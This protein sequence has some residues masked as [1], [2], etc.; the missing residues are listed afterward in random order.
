MR[1]RLWCSG[2]RTTQLRKIVL[3]PGRVSVSLNLLIQRPPAT[4]I[5]IAIKLLFL[6]LTRIPLKVKYKAPR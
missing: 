4:T 3:F 6:M 5:Y 1:V 2:G